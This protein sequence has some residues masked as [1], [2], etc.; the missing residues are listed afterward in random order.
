VHSFDAIAI[1]GKYGA[2][3]W[4]AEEDRERFAELLGS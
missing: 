4:V 1:N 3:C 2:Y